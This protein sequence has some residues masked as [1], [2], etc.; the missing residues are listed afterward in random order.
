MAFVSMFASAT[1]KS[2]EKYLC[3]YTVRAYCNGRQVGSHTGYA[4]DCN[5]A[6]TEGQLWGRAILH[7]ADC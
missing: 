2:S 3:K 1:T 5:K 6:Y 7:D 4:E